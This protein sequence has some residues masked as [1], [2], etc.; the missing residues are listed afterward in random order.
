MKIKVI[1]LILLAGCS[2]QPSISDVKSS[3]V[4]VIVTENKD[5]KTAGITYYTENTCVIVLK[6]Y[7]VCLLH[8]FRHCL[9]GQWHDGNSSEDCY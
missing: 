4:S 6:Q 7:P 9:E 2:Q 5:I 3:T 8:E 1:A